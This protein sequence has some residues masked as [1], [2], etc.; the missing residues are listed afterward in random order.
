MLNI[1]YHVCDRS[2]YNCR[3]LYTVSYRA[4]EEDII[5]NSRCESSKNTKTCLKSQQLED[6]RLEDNKIEGW[7]LKFNKARSRNYQ[8]LEQLLSFYTQ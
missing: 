8:H 7:L 4:T 5:M 6:I 2:F 3:E 1:D